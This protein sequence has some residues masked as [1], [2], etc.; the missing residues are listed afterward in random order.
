[1]LKR[2]KAD[3]AYCTQFSAHAKQEDLL[4]LLKQF[5]NL[6]AVIINHGEEKVKEKYAEKVFDEVDASQV[7]V[8]NR[9]YLFRLGSFGIEKTLWTKF[10]I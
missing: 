7:G 6:R 2:R 3:V 5:S 10:K 4:I 1:M 8:I 9:D